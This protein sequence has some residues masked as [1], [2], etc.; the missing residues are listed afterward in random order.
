MLA[1][2]G[3]RRAVRNALGFTGNCKAE[4]LASQA[5]P[6]PWRPA[7]GEARRLLRAAASRGWRHPPR[8]AKAARPPGERPAA[9]SRLPRIAVAASAQISSCEPRSAVDDLA[10]NRARLDINCEREQR[11]HRSSEVGERERRGRA[12]DTATCDPRTERRK[13]HARRL[14]KAWPMCVH[15][16]RASVVG[17]DEHCHLPP[18]SAHAC[19]RARR[20]SRRSDGSRAG[21]R[22]CRRGER[23][24]PHLRALRR[25]FEALS[26][27]GTATQSV[28][29][30]YLA[31]SRP[32]RDSR[33]TSRPLRATSAAPCPPS[34]RRPTSRARL[35]RGRS[36]FRAR[37]TAR[38]DLPHDATPPRRHLDRRPRG[39][40]RPPSCYR[41]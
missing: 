8:T 16:M 22:R 5:S 1:R 39:P 21:S 4:L 25:A 41:R 15:R 18:R 32:T 11:P 14:G 2:T 37:A 10:R 27:P 12:R 33:R 17:D 23:A 19:G 28:Q 20:E 26:S 9:R 31:G 3:S 36:P 30:A 35:R 7:S 24:R 6:T 29:Y 13:E 34:L 38:V 40:R